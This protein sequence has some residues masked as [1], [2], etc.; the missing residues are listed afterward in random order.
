MN[1]HIYSMPQDHIRCSRRDPV[2]GQQLGIHYVIEIGAPGKLVA[3]H[4]RPE[5]A[6]QLLSELEREWEPRDFN[7]TQ[8]G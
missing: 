6:S 7:S 3:L 1:V 2:P 5:A 4:L 8:P